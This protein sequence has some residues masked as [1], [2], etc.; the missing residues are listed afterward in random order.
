MPKV[1]ISRVGRAIQGRKTVPVRSTPRPLRRALNA[2]RRRPPG[3]VWA[4]CRRSTL[5]TAWPVE[6]TH[7]GGPRAPHDDRRGRARPDDPGCAPTHAGETPVAHRAPPGDE[8][9]AALADLWT[10][11]STARPTWNALRARRAP[12]AQA[13]GRASPRAWCRSRTDTRCVASPSAS[14]AMRTDNSRSGRRVHDRMSRRGRACSRGH[15]SRAPATH[16]LGIAGTCARG[17]SRWRAA[18]R[19]ETDPCRTH[20]DPRG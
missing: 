9:V 2:E 3:T 15:S 5:R 8:S 12:A 20:R 17:R 16:P 11:R 18:P 6:S 14:I 1:P 10:T 13:F 4:P 19:G 7:A